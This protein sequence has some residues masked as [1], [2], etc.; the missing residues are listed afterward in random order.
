MEVEV[1]EH[2]AEGKVSPKKHWR[3]IEGTVVKMLDDIGN[4]VRGDIGVV[5]NEALSM[6]EELGIDT[7]VPED[8]NPRIYAEWKGHEE[9]PMFVSIGMVEVVEIGNG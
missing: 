6:L 2:T 4:L 7:I 8:G 9:A 3:L 5:T 1:W